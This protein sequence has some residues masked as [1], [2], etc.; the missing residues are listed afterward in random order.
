LIK[1]RPA[2]PQGKYIIYQ[3]QPTR[4]YLF[5]PK[6]P[7]LVTPA[8]A[9]VHCVQTMNNARMMNTLDTGLRRYDAKRE[10]CRKRY[11]PIT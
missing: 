1:E 6:S 3:A 8:Q 9:G 7:I 5:G 10:E 11:I 4:M 2:P